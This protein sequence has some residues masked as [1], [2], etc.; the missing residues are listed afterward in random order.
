MKIVIDI[1][2]EL[3]EQCKDIDSIAKLKQIRKNLTDAVKYGTPLQ[4]NHGRLID[5]DMLKN[6]MQAKSEWYGDIF[7]D[8][9]ERV[10]DVIDNAPTIIESNN[11]ESEDEE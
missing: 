7:R 1:P 11:A 8:V 9:I 3:Y 10:I 6:D 2:E 5:V 4:K